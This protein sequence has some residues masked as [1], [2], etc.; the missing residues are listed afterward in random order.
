V[1]LPELVQ[2]M[3]WPFDRPRHQ[4]GVEHDVE[5]VGGISSIRF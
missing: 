1:V 5:R 2:Q 4:L 3:L